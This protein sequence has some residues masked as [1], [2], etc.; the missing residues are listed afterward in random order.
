MAL[1]V[2]AVPIFKLFL[3]CSLIAGCALDKHVVGPHTTNLHEAGETQKMGRHFSG[4]VLFREWKH[5][6]TTE[7]QRRTHT[8][9]YRMRSSV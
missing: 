9:T 8:H 3:G 7:Q 6:R 1:S 5:V 4:P 2:L